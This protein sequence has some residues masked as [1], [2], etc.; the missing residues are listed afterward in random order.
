MEKLDL[1]IAVLSWRQPLTLKNTLESYKKNGLLDLVKEKLVFFNEVSPEDVKIAKEYGFEVLSAKQNI[2]IGLPFQQLVQRATSKY[3]L[4][5]ENDFDLI[6][7]PEVVQARLQ[8]AVE[9]LENGVSAI[10]LRHR[11]HYGD[12]N[13]Y[14]KYIW[15]GAFEAQNPSIDGVYYWDDISKVYEGKCEK[16]VKPTQDIYVMQ[17]AFAG[18]TNNP[19]IYQTKLLKDNILPLKFNKT[20]VI[21][22]KIG[23]WWYKGKLKVAK[24][25]GL[26]RHH[27]IEISGSAFSS[28]KRVKQ[29]I[30]NWSHY[31]C[32]VGLRGRV[33][34][35][36]L[37]QF[38]PTIFKININ[39]ANKFMINLSLGRYESV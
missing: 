33:I 32:R 36:F 11:Y 39:V 35:L 13:M 29:P 26:F 10:R 9:L 31:I 28:Y 4:F 38:L 7:K 25:T 16:I 27:P 2:G 18:F 17:S 19:T 6:E 24:G 20:D 37:L 34:N 1:T 23:D 22:N 15:E 30:K 8:D 14:L 12:P 3:F 5:L 21:E